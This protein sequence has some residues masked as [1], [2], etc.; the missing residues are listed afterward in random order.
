MTLPGY[1]RRQQR[2]PGTRHGVRSPREGFDAQPRTARC[3]AHREP[4]EWPRRS[5]DIAKRWAASPAITFQM[6]ASSLPHAKL[7]RATKCR[8]RVAPAVRQ[9]LAA[10]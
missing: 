7:M 5:C 8:T 4:D 9:G 1:A 6:N 3:V 2:C 10:H